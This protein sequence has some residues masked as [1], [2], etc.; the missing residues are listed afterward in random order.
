MKKEVKYLGIFLSLFSMSYP[1]S[2]KNKT[3]RKIHVLISMRDRIKEFEIPEESIYTLSG[4]PDGSYY[5]SFEVIEKTGLELGVK[6]ADASVKE[7]CEDPFI[8]EMDELQLCDTVSLLAHTLLK[9]KTAKELA[10]L[11]LK[12]AIKTDREI[13]SLVVTEC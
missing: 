9:D 8:N 11:T 4:L 12:I 1:L 13:E 10:K 5:I 3:K 2:F 7:T 6:Q